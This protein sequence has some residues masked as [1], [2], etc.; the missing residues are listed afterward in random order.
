[1]EGKE[2]VVT[3]W[4]D[5]QGKPVFDR[6]PHQYRRY[7]KVFSR[8]EQ[9]QLPKHG[10]HNMEIDLEPGKQPPSGHLYPLSH[11]ELE[12]LQEYIDEMLKSGKIRPSKS[13]AGSP[14]FFVPKSHGRGLQ[15]VVDYRGLN[16]ITIKDRYPLPLISELMDRVGKARW[17][18]K[19]DLKNGFNLVHVAQGHK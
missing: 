15:V 7:A 16:A 12:A 13:P 19:L 1:M 3:L 17:F 2:S 10:P 8:Q 4:T 5:E 11:N 18:S 9:D 6:I 14:I